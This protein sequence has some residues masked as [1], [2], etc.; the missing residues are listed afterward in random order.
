MSS[1]L[2]IGKQ[3]GCHVLICLKDPE[4]TCH[5]GFSRWKKR[6]VSKS[7]PSREKTGIYLWKPRVRNSPCQ[8]Y[9]L[10]WEMG[11][12]CSGTNL[13]SGLFRVVQYR[14]SMQA[15][16]R[17]K[18]GMTLLKVVFNEMKNTLIRVYFTC[19]FLTEILRFGCADGA[20]FPGRSPGRSVVPCR[21]IRPIKNMKMNVCA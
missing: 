12:H 11:I 18:T 19:F 10:R 8:M 9:F 3:E 16:D 5:S 15:N 4:T 6:N 21:P 14:S 20:T 2:S 17:E 1:V 13:D 7:L